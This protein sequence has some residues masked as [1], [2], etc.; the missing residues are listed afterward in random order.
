MSLTPTFDAVLAE[1]D[2][3]I[4]LASNIFPRPALYTD[5]RRWP[6]PPNTQLTDTGATP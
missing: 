5:I 1:S 3:D 2:P 6:Y 4:F